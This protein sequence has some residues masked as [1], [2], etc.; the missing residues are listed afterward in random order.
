MSNYRL[1]LSNLLYIY[2]VKYLIVISVG[3]LF[4]SCSK[5]GECYY[6]EK[7]VGTNTQIESANICEDDFEDREQFDN[8]KWNYELRR[9][10]CTLD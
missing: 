6:C 10:V 3:L 7:P 4:F 2:S 1:Q 8:A 9:Y 5:E